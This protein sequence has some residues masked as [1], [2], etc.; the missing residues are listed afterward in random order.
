MSFIRVYI[1]LGSNLN[2]PAQ[3]LRDAL[4]ALEKLPHSQL[5]QVSQFYENP[6]M[7]PQDQPDFVN[8]VVALD[9]AL[10]P[11]EL[12]KELQKIEAKQG[13]E[14]HRH[15]GERT[16]DLDILLYGHECLDTKELTIPHPGLTQRQFV[17]L[18]LL[19]IAPDLRLP[20]GERLADLVVKIKKSP[21]K[22]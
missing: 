20:S 11:L 12:L 3:Q 6:P 22:F 2:H 14:R 18:P 7:G 1:G 5:K 21:E 9:T 4:Q 15:W 19:E 10:E 16:I 8:A 13:R 17:F